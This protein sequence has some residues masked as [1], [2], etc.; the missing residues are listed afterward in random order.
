MSIYYWVFLGVVAVVGI[1]VLTVYVLEQI[2]KHRAG[3][4]EQTG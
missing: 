1:G 2:D 4:Q 3:K